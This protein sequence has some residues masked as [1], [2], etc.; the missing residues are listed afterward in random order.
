MTA[1][2][3]KQKAEL[4]NRNPITNARVIPKTARETLSSM[5]S[6]KVKTGVIDRHISLAIASQYDR[7]PIYQTLHSRNTWRTA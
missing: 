2:T 3:N 1:L 6:H 4:W 5:K 7:A